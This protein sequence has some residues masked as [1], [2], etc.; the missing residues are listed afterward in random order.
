VFLQWVNK[1]S[2]PDGGVDYLLRFFDVAK[3]TLRS[4]DEFFSLP[5]LH[6]SPPVA[7]VGQTHDETSELA[8]EEKYAIENVPSPKLKPIED[9]KFHYSDYGSELLAYI[10][11]QDKGN[12]LNLLKSLRGDNFLTKSFSSTTKS[13]MNIQQDHPDVIII[14]SNSYHYEQFNIVKELARNKISIPI[15]VIDDSFTPERMKSWLKIG[16][17]TVISDSKDVELIIQSAKTHAQSYR[18]NKLLLESLTLAVYFFGVINH[19]GQ[20]L[21]P[22][23]NLLEFHNQVKALIKAKKAFSDVT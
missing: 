13:I 23:K 8:G 1:G 21:L 4:E 5:L 9:K 3:N 12:V 22:T 14:N 18:T 2:L 16:V 17:K 6:D 19:P 15:M 10:V 20:S 7:S 11:D